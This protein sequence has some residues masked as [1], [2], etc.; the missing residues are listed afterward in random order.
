MDVV[1]EDEELFAVEDNR[2]SKVGE[3]LPPEEWKLSFPPPPLV[4]PPIISSIVLMKGNGK[5]SWHL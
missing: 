5:V 4:Q 1:G 2:S 3:K